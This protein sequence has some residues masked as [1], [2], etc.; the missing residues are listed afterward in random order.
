MMNRRTALRRTA[1]T[2]VTPLLPF[3]PATA[4]DSTEQVAQLLRQGR[5]VVAFRHALAPGTFDPPQFKAGDCS[6]QRNLS[7]E[8]RYQARRIGAWFKQQALMPATVRSSPWCRCID[9]ATLAFGSASPWAELGSPRGA[10]EGTHREGLQT[11]RQALQHASARPGRFEA[12][13]SHMFVL[14]DLAQTNTASGE[15]LLLQADH[16]GIP[17]VLARLLLV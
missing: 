3:T 16:C 7:N 12:W 13:I 4:A 2:A 9:T 6:T 5:C 17:V 1:A 10:A 8:G 15:A 14:S 11:L